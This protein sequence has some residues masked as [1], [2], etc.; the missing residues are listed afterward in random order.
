MPIIRYM[1]NLSTDHFSGSDAKHLFMNQ[2]A[3]SFAKNNLGIPATR[4]FFSEQAEEAPLPL[5]IEDE[6]YRDSFYFE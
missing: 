1:L 5:D 2:A 6:V 3:P 4:V